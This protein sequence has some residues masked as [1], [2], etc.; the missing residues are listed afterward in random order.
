M[1]KPNPLNKKMKYQVAENYE[2]VPLTQ[3]PKTGNW[4]PA[5]PLPYHPNIIEK[6]THWFGK[7]WYYWAGRCV[8]CGKDEKKPKQNL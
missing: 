1:K 7:H 8:M 5:I 4:I 3:D 2:P 6:I